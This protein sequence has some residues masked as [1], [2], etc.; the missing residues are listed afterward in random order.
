MVYV[1]DEV[2]QAVYQ[3]ADAALR[4]AMDL[5]YLTGQRVGDAWAMDVRHITARGLVI[6]QAKTDNK[7]DDGGDGGAR[8][9]AEPHRG[10]QAGQAAEWQGEA[11]QHAADR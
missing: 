6:Q 4:D 2:F 5:A 3:H 7:G 10:A 8:R 1:E 9:A 11:V